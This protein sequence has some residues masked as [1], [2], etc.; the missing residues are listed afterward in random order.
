MKRTKMYILAESVCHNSLITQPFPDDWY[1]QEEPDTIG[2]D[3]ELNIVSATQ[4]R[5]KRL[6]QFFTYLMGNNY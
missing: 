3:E 4:N 1:G 5:H 6:K 2:D